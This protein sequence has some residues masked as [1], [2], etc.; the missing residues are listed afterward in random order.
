MKKHLSLIMLLVFC[1]S[2]FNVVP[3][4]A[5]Q[6]EY[7]PP[8]TLTAPSF[9]GRL[10]HSADGKTAT[11][12]APG[13]T[14]NSGWYDTN[15]Y[16]DGL[17][18]RLCWGASC[19]NAITWYLDNCEKT[20]YADLTGIERNRA[21]IFD[22]FRHNWNP[23][24]GYD[25]MQG[26]AWYFTGEVL[27]G[28]KPNELINYPSGG[29]LKSLPHCQD[30]WSIID[31]VND[32]SVVG[33][34]ADKFPFVDDVTEMYYPGNDLYDHA[35]FSKTI[36]TQLSYGVTVL[37]VSSDGATAT[38]GHA[39]TLW[40]CD[41]DEKTGLI[42]KIY[43][44]DSDDEDRHPGS[45][46]KELKIKAN[47]PDAY[48]IKI[49]GYYLN[50]S[51]TP[52]TKITSS[53]LLYAPDVVNKKEYNSDKTALKAILDSANNFDSAIYSTSSYE[54]FKSVVE[55]NRVLLSQNVPQKKIDSAVEEILVA[56]YDLQAY[57]N[58]CI[59]YSNGSVTVNYDDISSSNN[60]YSLLYGTRVTLNAVAKSGYKFDG[61]YEKTSNRFYSVN[62]SLTLPITSNLTFEARFVK[63]N[64]SSL[65]FANKTGQIVSIVNRDNADWQRINSIDKLLPKVPYSYGCTNGRWV[66]DENAVL[67]DLRQ[68]KD[69]LIMPQYDESGFVP[70]T[71]PLP[72]NQKVKVK[73]D[74]S[75]DSANSIGSFIMAVGVPQGVKLES[76]GV[77]FYF[78]KSTSF[79]PSNF[80][81][82]LNNKM[83]TS[84]FTDEEFK[85]YGI[86][87]IHSFKRDYNWSARA[88]VTYYDSYGNLIT[89][90]S[91]Q[92]N[93][94]D[95]QQIDN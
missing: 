88:Y 76:K 47:N 83:L 4:Y 26:F 10:T 62:D 81:L 34:Y 78:D 73:L 89:E 37:N 5:E 60:D 46:L 71:I 36:K 72:D 56:I 8:Y 16:W 58:L 57:F 38:G 70:P 3:A 61:W 91:N 82:T 51:G 69:V 11:L 33:N 93:I 35:S 85:D 92:I 1:I 17:D 48:G 77:A 68:G 87:N 52:I 9:D 24:E 75:L 7:V 43:V 12:F 50:N 41:Y 53:T 23:L 31:P 13:V 84:N 14:K 42:N 45:Y 27:S 6:K 67:L 55:K 49:E 25:P 40:G 22:N 79:N 28:G 66:Y 21:K 2:L 54:N 20:G 15:K 29:Y 63:N 39:I 59:K 30:S 19:T 80:I 74:Y 44:T 18:G 95:W 90:Y 94:V 65:K 32:Y 86:V 64:S